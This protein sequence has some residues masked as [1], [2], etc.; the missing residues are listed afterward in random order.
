MTPFYTC[1]TTFY[2]CLTT[3]YTCLT[4]LYTCL[5]IGPIRLFISLYKIYP[6]KYLS[7]KCRRHILEGQE[8][9]SLE[10]DAAS[11]SGT[12]DGHPGTNT[13]KLIL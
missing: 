11:A 6:I 1:L 13:L 8:E 9:E 12:E 3:L 4:K 10:A 5:T 2:T 7:H